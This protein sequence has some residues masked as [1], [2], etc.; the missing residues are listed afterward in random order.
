[1]RITSQRA[2]RPGLAR[3]TAVSGRPVPTPASA[4][5]TVRN[6]WL[7]ERGS[8]P[9]LRFASITPLVRGPYLTCATWCREAMRMDVEWQ[10]RES[11][12]LD[13]EHTVL[14]LP[15]GLCSA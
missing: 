10:L 6:D 13:A 5:A 14:M 7:R 3:P 2:R 4:S 8:D 12:P 15:G 11:G 1:M 9:F